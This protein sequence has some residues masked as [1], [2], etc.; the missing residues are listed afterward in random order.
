MRNFKNSRCSLSTANGC[1]K[2]MVKV[3]MT[4]LPNH[5]SYHDNVV[6]VP[7]LSQSAV[8]TR[9]ASRKRKLDEIDHEVA[10]SQSDTVLMTQQII[11]PIRRRLYPNYEPGEDD[12][13]HFYDYSY[14]D[15]NDDC[16]IPVTEPRLSQ[17]DVDEQSGSRKRKLD[18]LEDTVQDSRS[19]TF[20]V[21]REIPGAKRRR[22]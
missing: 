6:F 17:S 21:S 9:A 1:G 4:T 15:N 16:G 22:I 19:D 11:G 5:Y 18:E 14:C 10:G 2:T 7:R 3:K 20:L 13:I 8:D 12:V